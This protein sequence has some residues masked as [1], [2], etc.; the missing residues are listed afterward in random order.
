MEL[1]MT[2]IPPS[3]FLL[4]SCAAG[5][6]L[7]PLDTVAGQA[8]QGDH[9]VVAGAVTRTPTSPT[10][11]TIRVESPSA[12]LNWSPA[13]IVGQGPVDFLP[14][15]NIAT[16]QNGPNNPDFLVL[17]R[18][19]PQN[20]TR[21]V[22]LNG[23][24]LSRLQQLGGEAAAGGTVA[25]FTPA[26][27][28][29][30]GKAMFDVGN[31][32]L[33]TIE[34]TLDAQGNFF[35]ANSYAL[36]GKVDATS[37]VV[38]EDGASISAL[39]HGSYVAVAAPQV[40]QGG[41][42]RVNGS[43][44]YVAAESVSLTINSG[45]FDIQVKVGSSSAPAVLVHGGS[46]GGP[47]SLGPGDN[48]AIYMVAVPKN[49][50]ISLLLRGN[51]GYD[52]PAAGATEENG[53]IILSAGR[54]VNQDFANTTPASAIAA[55]IDIRGTVATSDLFGLATNDA[56]ATAFAGL[57][58]TFGQDVTLVA[59]EANVGADGGTLTVHGSAVVTTGRHDIFTFDASQTGNAN[60]FSRA[61]GTVAIDG[62]ARVSAS[63]RSIPG[64]GAVGGEAIVSA[65]GGGIAI[66][67]RLWIEADA[68]QGFDPNVDPSDS[69]GGSAGIGAAAGG[70]VN[71]AGRTEISAD[72]T[73]GV[74]FGV[75][76]GTPGTGTG[77]NSF[78]RSHGA[79]SA[80]TFAGTLDLG[81][82]GQGGSANSGT[83][84]G[85]TGGEARL[86]ATAGGRIAGV[87]ASIGATG[88][89]GHGFANPPP[90]PNMP[91][92]SGTGGAARVLINGGNIQF[93]TLF[94]AA[95]GVGGPAAANGQANGTGAGGLVQII[96]TDGVLAARDSFYFAQGLGAVDPAS[97][98][99]NGNVVVTATGNPIA[100]E[101]ML[102]LSGGDLTLANI[103]MTAH[104]ETGVDGTLHIL[105]PVAAPFMNVSAHDIDI[106][107]GGSVGGVGT[108][109]VRFGVSNRTEQT[110]I[111]GA[112]AGPGYTLDAAE[113]ARVR[114]DFVEI[115]AVKLGTAADVLVDD[116]DLPIGAIANPF[117]LR[118]IT[119]GT[120]RVVGEARLLGADAADS[121][122][123]RADERFELITPGGGLHLLDSAGN[124]AGQLTIASANI[125]AADS[126][127]AAQLAADPNFAGRDAALLA[128]DAAPNLLGHIRAGG[129][130]FTVGSTLF[131][132]NSGTPTDLAGVT[133]AGGGLTIAPAGPQPAIVVGFGRGRNPDGTF[134]T[135]D[136]FF[137][138]VA[139]DRANG[140]FT[141]DSE[142]NLC[143]INGGVCPLRQPAPTS[144]VFILG[145]LSMLEE[146][147]DPADMIDDRLGA[148][149]LIEEPVTSGGDSSFWTG[150]DDDEDDDDEDDEED[151]E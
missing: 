44:A 134:T 58:V 75:G 148:A 11:E 133:V 22:A 30:G 4:L 51:A 126:A 21:P 149:P 54:N 131:I 120:L 94:A 108:V 79:N 80:V 114:S 1:A 112:A 20:P 26:G 27:L 29:I 84:S 32:L 3:R 85:G 59:P 83:S 12:V 147:R 13:D 140:A 34:P 38:I 91:G 77:G 98:G 87:A 48:Q 117:S 39:E 53:A 150:V 68:E 111:G 16:F 125:V 33:T 151:E 78:V 100:G 105:G 37:A 17:N 65:D 42:V 121:L 81:A 128:N 127:L 49:T 40:R 143:K 124:P 46:T 113:L 6:L 69:L 10:T 55:N 56:I 9:M 67:G 61:G 145:P 57:P 110:V 50:A 141:D 74:G 43:T 8:F 103:R 109:D 18:I 23:V 106:A 60:L 119:D 93:D 31:L 142:F 47:A 66:G 136:A 15:G 144:S 5:A 70:T 137:A 122:T 135:G 63:T 62:D 132:Q 72:G 92:G 2:A 115:T 82:G 35:V 14:A 28:I 139:F 52:A 102:A 123:F 90:L 7:A 146:H 130:V 86:E 107:G 19:L 76:D 104:V 95:L 97:V 71:V 101:R 89:G 36:S 96:S 138:T 24:V 64:S 88:V 129:A 73:G 116:F 45:L 118:L 25:F 99:T 41:N